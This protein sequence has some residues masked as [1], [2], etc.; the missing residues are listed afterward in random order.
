VALGAD[1]PFTRFY[2]A[3]VH[4]LCGE[5]EAALALLERAADERPAFTAARLAIEPEF[6][7]LRA[8][9]RAQA[10]VARH[11]PVSSREGRA[12]PPTLSADRPP[13]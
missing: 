13:A 11:A 4:A 5:P 3:G 7:S 10:L 6:E 12:E 9:P 2:A 8:D 1:D